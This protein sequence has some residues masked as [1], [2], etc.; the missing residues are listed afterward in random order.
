M[1]PHANHVCLLVNMLT[2]VHCGAFSRHHSMVKHAVC[3]RY[4]SY[5]YYFYYY[6]Y[7]YYDYCLLYNIQCM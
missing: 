6:Y 7:D 1:C 5:H 2:V 4:Y 3:G